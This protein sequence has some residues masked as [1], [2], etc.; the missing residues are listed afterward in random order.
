MCV[1]FYMYI[2]FIKDMFIIYKGFSTGTLLS[3]YHEDFNRPIIFG[4][5]SYHFI[6]ALHYLVAIKEGDDTYICNI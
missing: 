1:C 2:R 3:A 6:I 4:A 5:L